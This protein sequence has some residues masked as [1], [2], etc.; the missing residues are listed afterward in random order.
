ML[1]KDNDRKDEVK[2]KTFGRELQGEWRQDEPFGGK[3]PVVK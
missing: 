3:P 1:H 2:K